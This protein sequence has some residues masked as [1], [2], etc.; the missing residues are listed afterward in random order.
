MDRADAK[1]R[2]DM[3]CS[4]RNGSSA[5]LN[6]NLDHKIKFNNAEWRI[7]LQRRHFIPFAETVQCGPATGCPRTMDLWVDT[8]SRANTTQAASIGTMR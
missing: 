7:A 5:W 6:A 2:R 1:T 3:V 4:S 8:L